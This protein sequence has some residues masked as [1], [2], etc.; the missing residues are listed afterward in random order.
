[1]R[2]DATSLFDSAIVPAPSFDHSANDLL[3]PRSAV[4]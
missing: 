1:M 2:G 3:M 4:K